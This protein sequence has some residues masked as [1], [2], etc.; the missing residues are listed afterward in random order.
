MDEAKVEI[1]KYVRDQ[2]EK[3]LA[4]KDSLAV[5]FGNIRLTAGLI[6]TIFSFSLAVLGRSLDT[7]HGNI[8]RA[9]TLLPLLFF[10]VALFFVSRSLLNIPDLV[11]TVRRFFPAVDNPKVS[12]MLK[13]SKLN[14]DKVVEDLSQNYMQAM[15]VNS[16][17]TREAAA[18]LRKCITSIR[19]ALFATIAFLVTTFVSDVIQRWLFQ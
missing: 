3:H 14:A 1:Y 6:L 16:Q 11:G 8:A 5:G 2:Y 15:E 13:R 18:Q 10:A 19:W 12:R 4:H 17:S 7:A 9:L